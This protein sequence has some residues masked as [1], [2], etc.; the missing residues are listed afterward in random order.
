[1]PRGV[2]G[3]SVASRSGWLCRQIAGT[4]VIH[5]VFTRR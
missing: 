2:P 4:L 5:A 1:M 3:L